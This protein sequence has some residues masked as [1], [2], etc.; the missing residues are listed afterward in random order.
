MNILLETR[1]KLSALYQRQ[2]ELL[3][4]LLSEGRA[5]TED[6]DKE[7]KSMDADVI[8]LQD[9]LVRLERN[10]SAKEALRASEKTVQAPVATPSAT[11]T[12]AEYEDDKG[13]FRGFKN[14]GEQLLIVHRAAQAPHLT[15]HRLILLNQRAAAGMNESVGADGGFLV[16]TD[17]SD[18][19]MK[20]VFETGQLASLCRRFPVSPG[21]NGVEMPV[22]D[23][24]SRVDGSRWG[25]VNVDWL[26]EAASLTLSKPKFSTER[27]TF[28]KLG[29]LAAITDEMLED[30]AFL[31]SFVSQAF[32]DEFA[33][34]IDDGILRGTGSGQMLGILNAACTVEQAAE[35]AQTADTIVGMNAVK[36]SARLPA[37]SFA[38][39]VWITN[40]DCKPQIVTLTITKDK[41]DIPLYAPADGLRSQLDTI[42]GRPVVYAEQASTIGDSGDFVL[43]DLK[44]YMLIARDI[45]QASSIHVYFSTAEQA[46]RFVLRVNGQPMRK[47]AI[48]PARGTNTLSPFVKLAAR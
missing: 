9:A 24:T 7:M 30:A 26:N 41:S 2:E 29:G 13:N 10:E 11:V 8:R 47:T 38:S 33:Y 37:R 44:S 35:S 31:E 1:Q 23:E 48:T 32:T 4:K 36:M 15:D 19:L 28:C 12:R 25:G 3:N 34:K 43:A 18:L 14:F 22:V 45:K 27:I 21:K 16:Q 42:M 6:E 17:F 39:S 20:E 40:Q 5:A 46:F